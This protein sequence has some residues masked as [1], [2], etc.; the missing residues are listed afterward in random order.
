MSGFCS[1]VLTRAY[2]TRLVSSF[3]VDCLTD[4][5]LAMKIDVDRF[6]GFV[7]WYFVLGFQRM[8][9]AQF[10]TAKIANRRQ[11]LPLAKTI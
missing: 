11:A 3:P 7:Y 5:A 2:P 6:D 4:D 1:V 10:G 9:Q 8:S